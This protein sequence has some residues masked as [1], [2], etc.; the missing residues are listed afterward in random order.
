MIAERSASPWGAGDH[1]VLDF[2]ILSPRSMLTQ[3]APSSVTKSSLAPVI[4]S[5]LRSYDIAGIDSNEQVDAAES[6]TWVFGR[7]AWTV[8]AL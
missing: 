3:S 8:G 7:S 5:S 1:S 4:F 6:C 2:D